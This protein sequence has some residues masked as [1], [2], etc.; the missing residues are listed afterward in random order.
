MHEY[1]L[2]MCGTNIGSEQANIE[3]E[4]FVAIYG[5]I[6]HGVLAFSYIINNMVEPLILYL[7]R[8]ERTF[9]SN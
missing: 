2:A 9:C 4:M 5:I 6:Y 8:V 1:V 3:G 7:R